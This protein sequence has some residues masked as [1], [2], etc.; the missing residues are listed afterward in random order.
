MG[1]AQEKEKKL[2]R[3]SRPNSKPNPEESKAQLLFRHP[4]HPNIKSV[5]IAELSTCA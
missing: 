2:K 5:Q 1:R 4:P 3:S